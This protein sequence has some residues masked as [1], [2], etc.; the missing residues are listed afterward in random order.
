MMAEQQVAVARAPAFVRVVDP[1]MRRLLRVGLPMGPNAL[2]TTRGRRS[3][4]PRSAGVAVVEIEGRRWVIGAYGETNWVRNLRAAGEAEIRVRGRSEA[5]RA[6]ELRGE[7]AAAFF[8][9]TL[10][11]YVR[12]MPLPLRLAARIFTGRILADPVG[13]AGRFPVFE[14]R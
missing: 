5:V 14:L 10:V 12:A 4:V 1:V 11:P 6:E 8:R 7:A 13:A 2:L 9:D 3:G